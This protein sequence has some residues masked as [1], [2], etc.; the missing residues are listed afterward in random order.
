MVEVI[1]EWAGKPRSFRLDFGKVMDLEQAAGEGIGAIFL[2][3]IGGQFKAS[4]VYHTIRLGLIGGGERIVDADMLIKGHFDLRPYMENAALA[5][6]IL[7]ALMAGIEPAESDEE[8]EP[9][10]PMVFSEVSQI[11]QV[12]NMSPLDLRAMEYADFVNMIRG[13]NA[14]SDQKIPHISEEEFEDIL[15]RYEPEK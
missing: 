14:G 2:A 5:G 4:Y 12:F 10:G 1:R 7:S 9:Q 6:E 3:V 8:S 11:C 13:F 15:R